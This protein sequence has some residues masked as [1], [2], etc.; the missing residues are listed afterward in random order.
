[1]K[2]KKTFISLL[3]VA[4]ATLAGCAN[5]SSQPVTIDTTPEISDVIS[6]AGSTVPE[7]WNT[8]NTG[9]TGINATVDTEHPAPATKDKCYFS[10]TVEYLPSGYEGRGDDYNTR[11][12]IYD[13]GQSFKNDNLDIQPVTVKTSK[14]DLAMLSSSVSY[15][16]EASGKTTTRIAVRAISSVKK[17]GYD[18][19][20]P[21]TDPY[22]KNAAE[23]LPVV[24]LKTDCVGGQ[25]ISDD[26]WKS[27]LSMTTV[28]LDGTVPT[29]TST[30]APAGPFTPVPVIPSTSSPSTS[31]TPAPQATEAT[32]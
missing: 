29:N 25:T 16:D 15:E 18:I 13:F 30:T 10:R 32:K 6:F 21:P 26:E 23:G 9:G 7:G 22:A 12:F 31:E 3:L 11:K 14:G 5:A 19:T 28:T 1:M 20:N 8:Q 17:S 24:F 27:L 4:G 2:T